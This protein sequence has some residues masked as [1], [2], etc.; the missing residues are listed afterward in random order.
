MRALEV[1]RTASWGVC[2]VLRKMSIVFLALYLH[3]G[4]N[5]EIFRVGG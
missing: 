2:Y 5:D 3:Y 1:G 4:R